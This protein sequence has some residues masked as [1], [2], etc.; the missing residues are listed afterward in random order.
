MNQ[1]FGANGL[2]RWQ[3]DGF[4][5]TLTLA[6]G[7]KANALDPELV[8]TLAEALAA[9]AAD[10]PVMVVL[11]GQD[12]FFSAGLDLVTLDSLPRQELASFCE[13]LDRLFLS[14]YQLPAVTVAAVN[15]HAVAGGAVLMFCCDRRIAAAGPAVIGLNETQLGLPFPGAGLDILQAVLDTSAF[16]TAVL[17]GRLLSVDESLQEKLIDEVVAPGQLEA[18]IDRFAEPLRSGGGSGRRAIKQ[19]LRAAWRRDHER[20][21]PERNGAFVDA[22]F[23]ESARARRAQVIAQLEKR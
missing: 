15:G 9:I 6:R 13:E 2:V 3:S 19:Q 22:W 18:A 1:T 12:R 11:T 4:R 14:L 23:S 7:K 16:C 8:G 21:W 5:G 10:P 17:A 20:D